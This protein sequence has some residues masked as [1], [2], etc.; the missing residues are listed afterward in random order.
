MMLKTKEIV[1][2]ERN[3][4]PKQSWYTSASGVPPSAATV[5]TTP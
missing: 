5:P 3:S 1:S 2:V 4:A